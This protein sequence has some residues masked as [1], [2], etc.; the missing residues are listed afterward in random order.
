M[1]HIK[2]NKHIKAWIVSKHYNDAK[3][4]DEIN[5]FVTEAD[6]KIKYNEMV[7]KEGGENK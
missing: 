5:Y 4:T 2:Y 6:A 7:I 1:I 3:R